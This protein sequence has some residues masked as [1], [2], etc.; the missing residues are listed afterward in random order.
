MLGAEAGCS[1]IPS[2]ALT[3]HAGT[4]FA[5]AARTVESSGARSWPMARAAR[6]KHGASQQAGLQR[7]GLSRAAR[8]SAARHVAARAV[9]QQHT[10]RRPHC[11]Q[12]L[13]SVQPARPH[14]VRCRLPRA[15][16]ALRGVAHTRR[17]QPTHR[18][19]PQH[20]RASRSRCRCRPRRTAL[21][22]P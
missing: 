7:E 19:L 21:Q 15:L 10:S 8:A 16:P 20:T 17:R 11:S 3:R 5:R 1:A 6:R 2:P 14:P 12:P 9:G 22:T 18:R 4:R 13:S